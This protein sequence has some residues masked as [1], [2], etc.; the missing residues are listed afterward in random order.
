MEGPAL[1]GPQGRFKAAPTFVNSR[2]TGDPELT[3]TPGRTPG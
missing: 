1:A 2:T 3:A